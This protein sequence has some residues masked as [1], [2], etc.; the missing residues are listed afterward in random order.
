MHAMLCNALA[1]TFLTVLVAILG[2]TCRR[3]AL[4]HGLWLVVMIKL[5]TPPVLPVSL[6]GR[7]RVF[8]FGVVNR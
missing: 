8:A 2:R 5:V 3:P 6:A 1:A 4:I 7:S